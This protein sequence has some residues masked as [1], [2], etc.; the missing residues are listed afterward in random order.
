M[1][2]DVVLIII[3]NFTWN[4]KCFF[5]KK[6]SSIGKLLKEYHDPRLNNIG[7]ITTDNNDEHVLTHFSWSK[8]I[9]KNFYK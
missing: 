2:L 5:M 9:P 6:Y 8:Q 4:N 3:T 7:V 1:T